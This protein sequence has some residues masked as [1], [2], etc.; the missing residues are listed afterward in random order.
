MKKVFNLAILFS[1]LFLLNSCSSSMS[2][3]SEFN[4]NTITV[5]GDSKDWQGNLFKLKDTNIG[6]GVKNDNENVYLCLVSG[7]RDAN[8]QIMMNGLYI[9]FDEKGGTKKRI[10]IKYPIGNT[11]S[12][13]R[14]TEQTRQKFDENQLTTLVKPEFEFY[15]GEEDKVICP[16]HQNEKQIDLEFANG[17]DKMIYELKVPFSA[18]LKKTTLETIKKL[19]IGVVVGEME[20]PDMNGESS[21]FEGGGPSG[22]MGGGPGGGGMGGPPGGMSGGMGGG[23]GGG[24]G[25]PG[26]GMSGGPNMESSQSNQIKKWLKVELSKN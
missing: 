6:V 24:S 4:N 23:P 15:H 1:V 7:D 13:F 11:P 9:W 20:S 8:R 16:I 22:G 3:I 21:G 18:I 10:G 14:Q 5:D 17:H 12:D 19:G 2:M 25:G 26:G